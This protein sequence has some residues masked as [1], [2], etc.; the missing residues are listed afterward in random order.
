M[1]NETN[2]SEIINFINNKTKDNTNINKHNFIGEYIAL[3]CICMLVFAILIGCVLLNVWYPIKYRGFNT[4]CKECYL[5][6]YQ[7]WCCCFNNTIYTS[8]DTYSDTSSISSLYSIHINTNNIHDNIKI[9]D[10]LQII[11]NT[12]N[13]D[14]I[15]K[16]DCPICI[17]RFNIEKDNIVKLEH[18]NHYYH[19]DCI[20]EW[21]KIKI[22]CPL[23][24]N[25]QIN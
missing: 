21:L 16:L 4:F 17:E 14:F 12:I 8:S 1:S 19:K 15:N 24:R 6:C 20:I 9:H 11:E 3:G 2:Y 22:N 10:N 18:C 23:C 25:E 7:L 5:S 13:N